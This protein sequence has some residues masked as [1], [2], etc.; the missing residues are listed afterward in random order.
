MIVR[1]LSEGQFEVDEASMGRLEALDAELAIALAGD[2]EEQF[3]QALSAMHSEVR[4]I[5]RPLDAATIVPSDL[6]LPAS[7]STL[8]EVQALLVSE[9]VQD[10]EQTTSSS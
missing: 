4:S 2:N 1:I 3:Q 5:G 10:G 6:T 8:A 7:G 9:D